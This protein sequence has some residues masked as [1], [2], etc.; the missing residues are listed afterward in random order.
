MK[1]FKIL[2]VEDEP[3][4]AD[5][6]A[7]MVEMLGHRVVAR[8]STGETAM[9]IAP[10]MVPDL[11]MTDIF[12]AGSIDGPTLADAINLSLNVPTIVMGGYSREQVIEM[13]PSIIQHEYLRKPFTS[14]GLA[15][16]IARACARVPSC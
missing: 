14:D 12:L 1:N 5:L 2:L 10:Y 9:R 11:V 8:V 13:E 15:E 4:L 7:R 3:D 6:I 16:A